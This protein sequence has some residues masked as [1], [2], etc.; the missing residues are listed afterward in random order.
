[1]KEFEA[2]LKIA[3]NRFN[4]V[5][6]AAKAALALGNIRKA[7]TY[8]SKLVELC[9]Q[10]DGERPELEQAK[11]SLGRIRI[12]LPLAPPRRSRRRATRAAAPKFH[13]PRATPA[14]R[15]FRIGAIWRPER[16]VL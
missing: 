7:K 6:G 13:T 1:M 2:A 11:K 5:Y 9:P 15:S 10:A 4:G 8:F 12:S 14:R 3:P 16:K